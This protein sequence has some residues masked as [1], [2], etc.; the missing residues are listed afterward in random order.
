MRSLSEKYLKAKNSW[1]M[2]QVVKY[3]SS[4]HETLSSNPSTAQ[5]KQT[6]KTLRTSE[7]SCTRLFIPQTFTG[8][9]IEEKSKNMILALEFTA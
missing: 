7:H 2:V 9:K 5:N 6:K 3:L 1:G 4:K 8:A